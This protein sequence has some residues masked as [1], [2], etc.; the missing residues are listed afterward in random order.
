MEVSVY[1]RDVIEFYCMFIFT[2]IGG[3]S[4]LKDFGSSMDEIHRLLIL[5][6]C[7]SIVVA[8]DECIVVVM[9]FPITNT[10]LVNNFHCLV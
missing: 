9:G 2:C 1:R 4:V 8:N 7:W 10:S 5:Q 3:L 6:P